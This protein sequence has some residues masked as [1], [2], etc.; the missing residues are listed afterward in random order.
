VTGPY[1][2]ARL[3]WWVALFGA[4]AVSGVWATGNLD[5]YTQFAP[6][7]ATATAPETGCLPLPAD[8]RSHDPAEIGCID[9]TRMSLICELEDADRHIVVFGPDDETPTLLDVGALHGWTFDRPCGPLDVPVTVAP[10][11]TV[12]VAVPRTVDDLT[13]SADPVTVESVPT[14]AAVTSPVVG[15]GGALVAAIAI[16]CGILAAICAAVIVRTRRGTDPNRLFTGRVRRDAFARWGGKCAYR[17]PVMGGGCSSYETGGSG[18]EGDHQIAWSAT[19]DTSE[20]NAQP[21]CARHHGPKGTTPNAEFVRTNA[22]KIIGPVWY[23]AR[24]VRC[25]G[26]PRLFRRT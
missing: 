21:L 13:Q 10:V 22:T 19:Q 23:L 12:A 9:R 17:W 14:P 6:S 11:S 26:V 18:L 4:G 1:S 24:W 25:E 7:P 16:G 3:I 20:W 5:D 15:L 2:S 8:L